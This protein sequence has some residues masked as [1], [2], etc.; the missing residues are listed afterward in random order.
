MTPLIIVFCMVVF[1]GMIF[2]LRVRGGKTFLYK[3]PVI[4]FHEADAVL[5]RRLLAPGTDC[6]RCI[7]ACPY[8]HPDELFHR[9]I[10]WGIK[11]NL[12]FRH[13]A[14]K[15][16]DLFYGRRPAIRPLPEWVDIRDKK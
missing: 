5:F 6:G 9:F 7:A 12:L 15:L 8:S 10:R 16:D 1:L 4:R 11:I 14:L 3:R 13:L 2:F